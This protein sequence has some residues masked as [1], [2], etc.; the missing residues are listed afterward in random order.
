MDKTVFEAVQILFP[1]TTKSVNKNSLYVSPT[2]SDLAKT[3]SPTSK[4][5]KMQRC[6]P[7]KNASKSPNEQRFITATRKTL[8]E[9]VRI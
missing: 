2:N 7:S 9:K 1:H 3:N 8:M 4:L 6:P 5:I